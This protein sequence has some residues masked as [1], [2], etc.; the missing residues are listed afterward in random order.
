MIGRAA[1]G[2]PWI[3]GEIDR[4]LATGRLLP[5]PAPAEV[6]DILLEHIQALYR[7]Y[8][9]PAGVRIARKHLGWYAKDRPGHEPFLRFV[10]RAETAAAQIALTCEYF[11]RLEA[12]DRLDAA[13]SRQ[14]R[15]A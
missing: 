1:Q 13:A 4:F 6:R 11:D 10:Y 14:N 3:F 2:R 9:E 8:G 7:F 12:G 15:A 5:E